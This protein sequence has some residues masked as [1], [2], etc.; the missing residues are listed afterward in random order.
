MADPNEMILAGST[1]KHSNPIDALHSR[2]SFV[3][4][5][6][7]L[8]LTFFFY[9]IFGELAFIPGVF[10]LAVWSS[11]RSKSEWAYWFVPIIIGTLTLGFC[12]L[13]VLN[14]YSLITSISITTLIFVLIL[15]YAI[16]SSVR[17]IRIHFHPVYRMGYSGESIYDDGVKLAQGEMLAACP[18]CLAVLAINPMLLSPSD[19]CPHCNSKLVISGEEE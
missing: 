6:D 10:F 2:T 3:L 4:A 15:A 17:F 1:P 19:V 14:V 11:Y 8:L 9:G 13:M 12:F 18:S 7:S 16:F 5:V